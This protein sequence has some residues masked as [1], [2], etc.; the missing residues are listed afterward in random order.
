MIKLA[1]ECCLNNGLLYRQFA[2]SAACE[3]TRSDANVEE[4]SLSL[5]IVVPKNLR[6][7][8]IKRF[9]DPPMSGHLVKYKTFERVARTHTWI[10]LKE[11][12]K[13][14]CQGCEECQRAKSSNQLPVGTLLSA[15][16]LGPWERVGVDFVGPL[17]RSKSGNTYTFVV[18]DYFSK[19]VFVV[20]MRSSKTR[21]MGEHLYRMCCK[22]GFPSEI[23]SDNCP[24]FVSDLYNTMWELLGT[25][26]RHTT[27]YQPQANLTE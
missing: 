3:S 10:G 20:A 19:Y 11:D 26:P 7:L 14:Y 8:V 25:P 24:Q 22:L 2:C 21:A 18:V 23:L 17:P 1:R 12:V 9:H 4:L 16:I 5:K 27:P 13:Q 15:P 6:F